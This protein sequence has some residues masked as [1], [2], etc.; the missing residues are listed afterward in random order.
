MKTV[1]AQPSCE[2]QHPSYEVPHSRSRHPRSSRVEYRTARTQADY[3]GAFSRLH[4]RFV[5]A[6]IVSRS[7]TKLRVHPYHM[8]D[9]SQVF[10]SLQDGSVTGTVT[11][12]ADSPEH[13]L[14]I[15]SKY[16]EA[17]EGLRRQGRRIGEMGS[18]AIATSGDG[19]E[20]LGDFEQFIGLTRL[21]IH[22]AR[23]QGINEIVAVVHPK[24][25]RFYRTAI[26][27]TEL[28]E[29]MLVPEVEGRPG[30]LVSAPLDRPGDC[31]PRW[32]NAYFNGDFGPA[33]LMPRPM[34]L[35]DQ[36]YFEKYVLPMHAHAQAG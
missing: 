17:I 19:S 16:P 35:L 29:Q 4:Q 32:R 9:A 5:D 26:G 31:H 15:E 12:I 11:L 24:H 13:G 10:V 20:K 7:L 30:V 6:G 25:A 28:G 34:E 23:Q 33:E 27:F 21:M 18:L 3:W 2:V 1:L 8:W 14:P 22:F 36:L